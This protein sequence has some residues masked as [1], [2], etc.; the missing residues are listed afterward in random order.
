MGGNVPEAILLFAL[1]KRR[2]FYMKAASTTE[3]TVRSAQAEIEELDR[4]FA[5]PV[6]P[7]SFLFVN[8]LLCRKQGVLRRI[9][10][11]GE[12]RSRQFF[13]RRQSRRKQAF[14]HC[15]TSV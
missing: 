4:P 10:V 3:S 14:E 12:G 15:Q 5:A 9:E 7:R 8:L 2:L 1:R 13:K 6:V 11:F